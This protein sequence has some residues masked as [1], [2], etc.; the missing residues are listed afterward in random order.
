MERDI[1]IM[2]GDAA[3]CLFMETTY[4]VLKSMCAHRYWPIY[5]ARR[6]NYLL[7]CDIVFKPCIL[8]LQH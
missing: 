3:Q 7:L 1:C 5:Q 6:A 4:A 2:T 8:I